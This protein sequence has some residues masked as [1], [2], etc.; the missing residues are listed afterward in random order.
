MSSLSQVFLEDKSQRTPESPRCQTLCWRIVANWHTD[1]NAYRMHLG[2]G[3]AL[4]RSWPTRAIGPIGRAQGWGCGN[5][6]LS[7]KCMA[8]FGFRFC[9]VLLWFGHPKAMMG[10]SSYEACEMLISLG[11]REISRSL[12]IERMV[13]PNA[14][15]ICFPTVGKVR[16]CT[17]K[18]CPAWL[19]L[20]LRFFFGWNGARWHG[21]A[22]TR[23]LWC[24]HRNGRVW[25]ARVPW[26]AATARG[27][28]RWRSTQ[29]ETL[30]SKVNPFE[31]VTC[32]RSEQMVDVHSLWY[33][34]SDLGL[35]ASCFFVIPKA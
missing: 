19:P 3:V 12:R 30:W 14:S 21:A 23:G 34:G 18:T 17:W 26:V 33:W 7:T 31:L 2:W 13:W 22:S 28:M 10:P 5:N 11:Y 35:G 27:P 9:L 16:C 1:T 24:F 15:P 25:F 29:V 4:C 20:L 6:S 32:N 8:D